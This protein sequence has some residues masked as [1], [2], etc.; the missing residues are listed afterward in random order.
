MEEKDIY[1]ELNTADIFNGIGLVGILI[2][3]IGF[4]FAGL[5]FGRANQ[6]AILINDQESIDNLNTSQTK[7]VAL[8]H[9][10]HNAKVLAILIIILSCVSIGFWM[11]I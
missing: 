5:A 8:R 4:I 10:A 2:P 3:L 11:K 6:I 1:K 7:V 9:R